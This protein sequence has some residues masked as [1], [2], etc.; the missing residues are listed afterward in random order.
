MLQVISGSFSDI[1][2]Q[3]DE[4]SFT[5]CPQNPSPLSPPESLYS[6]SDSEVEFE[7]EERDPPFDHK[8]DPRVH[9]YHHKLHNRYNGMLTYLRKRVNS[10]Y[11]K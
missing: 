11:W 6:D 4:K 8:T 2:G 5:L 10:S 7:D 1:V 9:E 3:L